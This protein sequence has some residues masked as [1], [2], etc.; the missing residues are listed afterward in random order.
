MPR[1]F[2]NIDAKLVDALNATIQVSERADFCVGYFNLRGWKQLYNKI[3]Q[4]SGKDG[5]CCR[6]LVGMQKLPADELREYFRFGAAPEGMDNAT[7]ARMKKRLAEE[8]RNQLALGLPTDEDET[9]LK[10][11]AAQIKEKKVVVKLFLPYGLHAKLYLLFRQDPA[12]PI[13]GFLG[14]S[15]LTLA[16]LSRQGELN[17]DVMDHDA[18]QKLAKWFNDRWEHQ[19]CVDISKELVEII[20]TSWAGLTPSPYHIYLKIAYHLSREAREGLKEF[21]IPND[22]GNTLFEFQKAA[23]KIS[24]HH[25]NK[26]NG[27]LIGDVVGLGKTLM[28]TALARIFEDDYD[29]ETLIICPKNLQ[30]M[31]EH[32]R[33]KYR[34][35][36]KVI[37]VTMV[38]QILPNL[39]RYRLVLIDESHN[40][41]NREGVRYKAIQEYIAKND[42]K[43]ILL[44]ATPY[45]KI[46]LD[47]SN[48][49]RLFVPE[50]CD[51]G[52]RPE[53]LLKNIGET[54]FM[55]Q[56]QCPVKTL[57]AF[58][59]STHIDDWRELL[60]L[61]MVR[62]TRS[63]IKENYAQSEGGKKYLEFEDKRR[64]YF[65]IRKPKTL[66]FS[67]DPNSKTDQYARLFSDSVVNAINELN[68]PRYGLGNYIAPSPHDPPKPAD[69]KTLNNLSR[70]GKQLKG[71]C[72]TGLFKRLE[73]SG[74]AF[75]LSVERHVLRNYI[76]LY[77][78]ENKLP[79]PVGALDAGDLDSAAD[80]DT[81]TGLFIQQ[82]A[83]FKTDSIFRE[84]AER[85]Y[86]EYSA[87]Y[88]NRFN[89]INSTYF[90][91][92]LKTDIDNDNKALLK[93][94]KDCGNWD[95]SKDTKL[96]ELIKLTTESYP[97]DKIL[98]FTQFAD[99]VHYLEKAIKEKVSHVE[100]VT[101]DSE[102][103]T[104][105]A[106][107][108]SPVSNDKRAEVSPKDE[109]RVLIATD[110]LS[111][112][113]NLQ[114]SFIVVNYD[115][116]WAIIKLIQRAGRVDRIGQT[117]ENIFCYSFMPAEGVEKIINLR[118]RVRRRLL[119]N[120]EV[121]GS[122]E[123]FFEDDANN[124]AIIDL[125]H[126]KSEILEGDAEGEVDLA[127]YAY[128]IWKNAIEKD[129]QLAK[130]I[131]ALQDVVFSTKPMG[132]KDK[133]GVLVYARTG[134]DNDAM[135]FV[136]KAGNSI[137]ESQYEILKIAECLP[138]TPTL[139]KMPEHHDLVRKAIGNILAENEKSV[140]GNLGPRNGARYKSYIRLKDYLPE[141]A[142]ELFEQSLR[143]ALDDIFQHPLRPLARDLLNRQLKS[144][145][146]HFELSQMVINLRAEGKL[147]VL[148]EE[149]AGKDPQIICSLGI[150][151]SAAKGEVNAT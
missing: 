95:S 121:V 83:G 43:A 146:S 92:D 48:Q 27:V 2:D 7:A 44:T 137:T 135:A 79:L 88:Q 133:E 17:V 90:I 70:A 42:S 49:L 94:L 132:S 28:A 34:L 76:Y 18:C 56:H 64:F 62:R 138:T 117:A 78:F 35:R 93:I 65:P 113:Q 40:L 116:P 129:P 66:K 122:D 150:S 96:V 75:L 81:D 3:D 25:L 50:D 101:G 123:R 1:I 105:A 149:E 9:A 85:I 73:S 58:E 115:L 136:D 38:A 111:E 5:N 145:I 80:E 147:C 124:S 139:S 144:G 100:G 57:P 143:K 103:P 130:V 41:R 10:R 126:E 125:Y 131:P 77:A 52:I 89:W 20:E 37:P 109:L 140:G 108:F 102:D 72:R 45:N 8:F 12:N 74:Q 59:K 91:K 26:R 82:Q 53:K 22:F 110:V 86:K 118:E 15:N 68:L 106:W 107:R 99:T 4:L 39:R 141:I 30:K 98:I 61:F 128:Q 13:I 6:L 120:G 60:R 127:S 24:A 112:G 63:F 47:I 119:E 29:I 31:W 148:D 51:L 32:Y 21:K 33:E 71:F 87:K 14:S 69:E 16:G 67:V 54:E 46:F 142:G 104:A 84:E 11:L 134:D 36:G 55:R 97:K 151:S 114:D 19:F 23:V